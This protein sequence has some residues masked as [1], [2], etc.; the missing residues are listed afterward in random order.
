MNLR[1]CVILVEANGEGVIS[2]VGQAST[3]P[4]SWL[5]PSTG[6]LTRLLH[7]ILRMIKFLVS[8]IVHIVLDSFLAPFF[9]YRDGN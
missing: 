3:C 7:L 1:L 4:T 5:P 9:G 8:T 2:I 6:R